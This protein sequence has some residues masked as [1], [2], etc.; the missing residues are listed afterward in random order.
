MK[1][2][3][4]AP[5]VDIKILL[6]WV[7][8]NL[9][10]GNADAH[11][12]NL[13]LLFT[14]EGPRLAPFYDMLCTAIYGELADKLAM[15]I[16]GE[17]RPDWIQLRHLERFA[18]DIGVH[19]RMVISTV[20]GMAEGIVEASEEV[21]EKFQVKYGEKPVVQKV[22]SVIKKRSR[23]VLLTLNASPG[24]TGVEEA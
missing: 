21:A 6:N 9:L 15:K 7:A 5:A 3:S 11:A 23:S 17:N 22:L 2:R 19:S 13:A 20:K 16:G 12:K 1:D 18:Q 14:E 24:K 10:I 8:F 4:I